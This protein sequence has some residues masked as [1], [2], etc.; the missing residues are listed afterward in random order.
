MGERNEEAQELHAC[1]DGAMDKLAEIWDFI[2]IAGESRSSRRGIVL[3]H[4]RNLLDEMVREEMALRDNL[5]KNIK[6]SKAE[7]AQLCLELGL[8]KHELPEGLSV[9]QAEKELKQREESL[10]QEKQDRM[11]KLKSLI[12]SDKK[13]SETLGTTSYHISHSV[14]PTLKQLD[15]FQKHILELEKE[16]NKRFDTLVSLQRKI[17]SLLETLELSPNTSFERNVVC[18]FD[19][20]LLTEDNIGAAE[21]Y[22]MELEMLYDENS[23][24]VESLWSK[25]RSLWKKL[26]Q[27]G[28]FCQQFEAENSGVSQRVIVSLTDELARCEELKLQNIKKFVDA[29]RLELEQMWNKCY[30][31]REVRNQF[32]AYFEEK[33]SEEL[34]L[35]HEAEVLKMKEFYDG[36]REMLELVSKRELLWNEFLELELRPKTCDPARFSN[37]GGQLLI[38][39]KQRKKVNAEL[40]RVESSVLA[41]IHEWEVET[42][43]VFL[44]GGMRYEEHINK[45]KMDLL[46]EKENEKL[47]RHQ[48]REKQKENEMMY[49]SKPATPGSKRFAAV[50][51]SKTPN[52]FRKVETPSS[53]RLTSSQKSRRNILAPTPNRLREKAPNQASIPHSGTMDLRSMGSS[54][55]ERA[56]SCHTLNAVRNAKQPLVGGSMV[57]LNAISTTVIAPAAGGDVSSAS[58]C[59]VGH[60]EDFANGLNKVSRNNSR[61]TLIPK[62][63]PGCL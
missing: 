63:G 17:S 1:V 36:N 28:G 27:P 19:L 41:R 9:L 45:Q 10:N 58:L 40:P 44:I 51:P 31:P 46:A 14:V 38:E 39:E 15:D 42:G 8:P 43:K 13:L 61:S 3:M 56:T 23:I 26:E 53:S 7:V 11:S 62:P 25:I 34:L 37:R 35:E 12:K 48:Q 20:L 5:V 47:L 33:M 2:G 32:K 57:G 16:K 60:Y 54:T 21:K 52:K 4:L 6:K 55:M 29:T 18:E 59:P 24:Q 22:K 30:M 49:G 50:T